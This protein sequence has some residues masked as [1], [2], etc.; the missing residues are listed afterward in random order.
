ML[1]QTRF[2]AATFRGYE[3]R[4]RD[5]GACDEHTLRERLIAEPAATPSRHVVVTV[6]DWIADPDGLFSPTSI[7]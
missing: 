4:V 3:R 7:C 5:S 6:G 2:L 1:A